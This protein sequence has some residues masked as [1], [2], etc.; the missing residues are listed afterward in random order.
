MKDSPLPLF[1]LK[2][3]GR[4]TIED[5]VRYIGLSETKV[6]FLIYVSINNHCTIIYLHTQRKIL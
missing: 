6:V 4:D 5:H 3:N 2:P 1:L